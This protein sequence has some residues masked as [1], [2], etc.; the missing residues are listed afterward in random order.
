MP[1]CKRSP[2]RARVLPPNPGLRSRAWRDRRRRYTFRRDMPCPWQPSTRRRRLPGRTASKPRWGGDHGRERNSPR[3]DNV[4]SS[5]PRHSPLAR[6]N[7]STC[8]RRPHRSHS[9][10]PRNAPRRSDRRGCT[11]RRRRRQP[12]RSNVPSSAPAGTSC[13]DCQGCFR[14]RGNRPHRSSSGRC[15]VRPRSDPTRGRR[16][17]PCTPSRRRTPAACHGTFPRRSDRPP[18]R[19]RDPRR[20]C[21]RSR[22]YP[23]PASPSPAKEKKILEGPP[24]AFGVRTAHG[25]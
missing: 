20:V 25:S 3:C 11:G 17:P 22:R 8:S 19:G 23:L 15:A 5:T 4:P 14:R 2:D 10:S 13:R 16:N 9:E 12:S 18:C 7:G 24:S 6:R 1:P 21:L